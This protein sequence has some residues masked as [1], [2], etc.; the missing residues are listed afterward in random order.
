MIHFYLTHVL[1][2]WK[3]FLPSSASSYYNIVFEEK[4]QSNSEHA[5]PETEFY[6]AVFLDVNI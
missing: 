1:T 2:K 4:S 5:E 6:G 3:Q